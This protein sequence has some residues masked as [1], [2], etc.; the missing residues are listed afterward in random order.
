MTAEEKDFLVLESFTDKGVP[1]FIDGDAKLA[2][3]EC[4]PASTFKVV[5]A[6]AGLE[7][8][9]VT[10]DTKIE[11]GDQHVPNTPREINLR[12]ALYYSSNDFFIS[13]AQKIGKEKLTEY[14]QQS[15]M[16]R[17]EIPADWLGDEWR[18]VIKGGNLD[19][20]PMQNHLFMRK[21]AF[22]KLSEN[23]QVSKDL[24]RA[25]NW[26][27]NHPMVRLYGKTGVWGGAVWFNGFGVKQ[28]H[29]RVRTVFM[30][31]SIE[32]RVPTIMTFYRGWDIAWSPA[33]NEKV[34]E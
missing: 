33:L 3:L 20:T 18:P 5:I 19:T 34:E 28:R 4:S 29:R 9:A 14:V 1:K 13:L 8:G 26:P 10:L 24:I 27:T 23:S 17:G 12:Q 32:R 22:S 21:V 25:L 6:W 7:T 16:F 31:G 11:V 2:R 30:Q 15:G